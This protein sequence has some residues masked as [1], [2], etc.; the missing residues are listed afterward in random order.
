M[1]D[2]AQ[3]RKASLSQLMLE[4][5]LGTA[6]TKYKLLGGNGFLIKNNV[7]PLPGGIHKRL[8]IATR[9][10]DE[11]QREKEWLHIGQQQLTDCGIQLYLAFEGMFQ[12]LKR[13]FEARVLKIIMP[14]LQFPDSSYFV[15]RLIDCVG[16]DSFPM[17][18]R[19]FIESI[20]TPLREVAERTLHSTDNIN[21]VR[22]FVNL[23]FAKRDFVEVA[24]EHVGAYTR[25]GDNDI[26][27]HIGNLKQ[28][29]SKVVPFPCAGNDPAASAEAFGLCCE[30]AVGSAEKRQ[31]T[32]ERL[33]K[34][35]NQKEL[36]PASEAPI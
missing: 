12:D 22:G 4:P 15:H 24:F 16:P 26:H 8:D 14:V 2:R 27:E 10:A 25:K 17:A 31:Q 3:F 34:L 33:M 6:R 30:A 9:L 35:G 21:N 29:L 11:F 18:K 36:Y 23:L 32:I 5:D 28:R 20:G 13:K 7:C 1:S 19:E